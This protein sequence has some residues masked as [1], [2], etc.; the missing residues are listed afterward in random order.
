MST[1]ILLGLIVAYHGLE[2]QVFILFSFLKLEKIIKKVIKLGKILAYQNIF[3]LLF[4][5]FMIDNCADDWR[6]AMTWQ[7]I[8]QIGTELLV[9]AV[10]PIPG[11]YVFL[12][13]TKL[14]NHGGKIGSQIVPLDVALS[15]PMFLRLYLICRYFISFFKALSIT[16]FNDQKPIRLYIFPILKGDVTTFK[17]VHRCE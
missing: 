11:H 8:I 10:H 4:Q 3:D 16:L 12:W 15:L 7:R 6:I 13:T 9:C 14:S 1:V 17:A 5:L 2:V